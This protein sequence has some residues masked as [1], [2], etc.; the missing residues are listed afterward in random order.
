M[1][2]SSAL[3]TYLLRTA[4]Y[5]PRACST[6]HTSCTQHFTHLL[7]T[8]LYIPPAHST[9]RTSCTQHFTYLPHTAFT[10]LLHS[11][12]R[13]SCTQHFTPPAH[14]TL[15]TSCTQHFTYLPHT[16]LYVPPAYSTL[17]TFC[18]QHFTYPIYR[19]HLIYTPSTPSTLHSPSRRRLISAHSLCTHKGRSSWLVIL[20]S[21]LALSDGSRSCTLKVVTLRLSCWV[22]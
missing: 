15:H 22:S 3:F 13:T 18:I 17:Q 19:Q 21:T 16:A 4:L 20:V 8:A 2:G 5:I 7:H 12:L 1:V 11:T 10:Y 14:S 6:L 9:L